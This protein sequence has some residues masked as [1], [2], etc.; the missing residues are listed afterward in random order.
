MSDHLQ[1]ASDERGMIILMRHRRRVGEADGL[2][3]RIG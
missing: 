1:A 2:T 3:R